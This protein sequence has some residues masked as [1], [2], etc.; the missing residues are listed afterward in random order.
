MKYN[1]LTFGLDRFKKYVEIEF[2]NSISTCWKPILF[3]NLLGEPIEVFC[4]CC[5]ANWEIFKEDVKL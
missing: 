1:C 2:L 4:L 3:F 5:Q